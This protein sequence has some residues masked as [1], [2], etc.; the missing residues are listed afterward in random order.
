MRVFKYLGG[1]ILVGSVAILGFYILSK[2]TRIE[3]L[4]RDTNNEAKEITIRAFVEMILENPDI[5]LDSAILKFENAG[6]GLSLVE[7]AESK[8]RNPENYTD[9]YRQYFDG[10]KRVVFFT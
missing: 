7:F 2:E 10:A 8:M 4:K 1:G 9:A 5:D 3:K 6:D